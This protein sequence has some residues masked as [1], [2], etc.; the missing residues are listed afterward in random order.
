MAARWQ[1]SLEGYID[2]TTYLL[3]ADYAAIAGLP[4]LA[5]AESALHAPFASFGGVEAYPT[6]VEQAAVLLEHLV[7]NQRGQ[8]AGG[9]VRRRQG[10]CLAD[11]LVGSLPGH[12]AAANIREEIGVGVRGEVRAT[13]PVDVGD[14]LLQEIRARLHLAYTRVGL[15]VGDAEVRAARRVQ[16]K[17]RGCACRRAR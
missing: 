12:A 10:G 11:D 17:A 7:K 5:L 2:I 1:P 3:D 8:T 13:E 6:L 15:R 9:Q 14:E 4:R 16:A